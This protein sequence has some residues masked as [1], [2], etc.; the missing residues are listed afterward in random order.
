M[1]SARIIQS[2]AANCRQSLYLNAVPGVQLG[3]G[4]DVATHGFSHA[5]GC[6]YTDSRVCWNKVAPTVIKYPMTKCAIFT[7]SQDQL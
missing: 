4:T 1:P 7:N 2:S 6:M 3:L 5:D